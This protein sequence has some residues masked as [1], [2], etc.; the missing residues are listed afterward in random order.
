MSDE[1]FLAALEACTLPASE[2]THIAHVRAAYLYL[3]AGSFG[4]A[5][6]RAAKTIRRYAASLGV[7]GRYHETITVAYVALIH[8]RLVEGGD[9]G[10]WEGFAAANPEFSERDLLLRYFP[11]EQLESARA[12]RVFVLPTGTP[13]SSHQALS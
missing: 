7:P 13:P 9:R 4:H 6:E 8:E 5:I 10:G 1:E 12:R 2:F 3:R 11:R